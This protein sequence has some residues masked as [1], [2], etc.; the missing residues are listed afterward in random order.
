MFICQVIASRGNG[1]LEKHVRELSQ[2][3]VEQGHRVLVVGDDVF[4]RTLPKG[5]EYESIN[6]RLSRYNPWLYYQLFKKL[7][8]YQFDVIHAQANKAAYLLANL[9]RFLKPSTVATVHNIKNQFS[10]YRRFLHVICV[11]EYL[12]KQVNIQGAVVIYNGIQ[13]PQK[14]VVDIKKLYQLPQDK[15][16]ICAVGRLV[17]AKGFDVLLEAI[18]GL[19]LSLVIV[20]DG[21]L[22]A[23]LKSRIASIDAR[24]TVC[25]T[26][27]QD[28]PPALMQAVDGLVISSRREGFS[29]VLNE[30]LLSGVNIVSTD[31][32]VANEVLADT[33]IVPVNDAEALRARLVT[34]LQHRQT[35][36]AQMQSAFSYAEQHMV[37]AQMTVKTIHFYQ[38]ILGQT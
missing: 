30:A 7:R 19:A 22:S 11:S 37:V 3:L 35:W 1:G 23:Q 38:R 10:T 12:Q 20:G 33:L 17:P 18:D 31:V 9:K 27:H 36:V 26:G 21:P 34:L 14:F 16:I 4:V 13:P 24:T 5:I 15:P 6:M 32:P 8:Q 29:Y 28:N 2:G 25:L